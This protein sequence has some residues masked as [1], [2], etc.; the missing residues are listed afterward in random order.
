[1]GLSSSQRFLVSACR[2]AGP[3]EYFRWQQV[4]ADL[5]YSESETHEAVRSLDQRKLL[6]LLVEGNARV[7]DAGRALAERLATKLAKG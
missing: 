7:L 5:G 4:G 6:I 2:S 3:G 1:M